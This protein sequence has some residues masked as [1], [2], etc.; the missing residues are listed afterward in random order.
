[1]A[2]YL[3]ELEIKQI[4]TDAEINPEFSD[5][6]ILHFG[7]NYHSVIKVSRIKQLILIEGNQNTGFKHINNRHDYF[8]SRSNWEKGKLG[9]GSKFAS[10][11]LGYWDYLKIADEIYDSNNYVKEERFDN[12]YE[13]Y[14]KALNINE[15]EC[16]YR[17][18][19]YKGTKIIHNLF[20]EE[21]VSIWKRPNG[22]NFIRIVSNVAIDYMNSIKRV[23][24]NYRSKTE[25]VYKISIVKNY[26]LKTEFIEIIDLIKNVVISEIQ[27]PIPE[28]FNHSV[29]DIVM[30]DDADL[31]IWEQK[32]LDYKNELVQ[33]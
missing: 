26:Y 4:I 29:L 11:T 25:V 18:L 31:I 28:D 10:H 14:K 23:S 24:I 27:N 7:K 17:L 1:M 13:L 2:K 6:R 19:L 33:V 3:T 20:P 15:V 21:N 5:D 32:I 22:F 16:P 8:Q 12:D 9:S 30:Y